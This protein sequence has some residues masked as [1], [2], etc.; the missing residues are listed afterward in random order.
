MTNPI[1]VK[2]NAESLAQAHA[3]LTTCG[4]DAILTAAVYGV[5]EGYTFTAISDIGV[6]RIALDEGVRGSTY[7]RL[8][9]AADG[10]AIFETTRWPR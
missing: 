3:L 2:L 9:I 7:G 6:L 8:M 4:F 5:I 1:T 10:S